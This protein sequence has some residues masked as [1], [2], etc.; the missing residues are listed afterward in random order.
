MPRGLAR[1]PP[2]SS[3]AAAMYSPLH[4]I[5]RRGLFPA[6]IA[7]LVPSGAA[8]WLVWSLRGIVGVWFIVTWVC[9]CPHYTLQLDCICHQD[10]LTSTILNPSLWCLLQFGH[11]TALKME[12]TVTSEGGHTRRENASAW[13]PHQTWLGLL[14]RGGRSAHVSRRTWQI[15]DFPIPPP[16]K[17]GRVRAAAPRFTRRALYGPCLLHLSGARLQCDRREAGSCP[18]RP[19]SSMLLSLAHSCN[20]RR[21]PLH[22][23]AGRI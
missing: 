2:F 11:S 23:D 5:A 9:C 15:R 21:V 12:E 4:H 16:L 17:L 1:S 19:P 10:G 18:L 6:P 3:V 14:P 22:E 8:L 7:H 13:A 20:L